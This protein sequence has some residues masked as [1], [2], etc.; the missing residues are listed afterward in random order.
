MIDGVQVER[1]QCHVD[2]RGRLTELFRA[3]DGLCEL[4]GQVHIT[5]VQPGAIKAWHRHLETTDVIAPV[6][7]T[8]RLGLADDRD[9]SKTEGQMNEFF[10]TP[11]DPM[12][13]LIPPGVWFGLKG[14]GT[15]EAV[16]AVFS[17]RLY[18]PKDPDQQRLDPLVNELPFD[19]DRRDR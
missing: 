18:D 1:L 19:W 16:V 6:A 13:V 12:K 5:T 2:E 15:Q 17:D 3:D 11:L 7:G 4:F 8:A 14:V 9:G 10:L